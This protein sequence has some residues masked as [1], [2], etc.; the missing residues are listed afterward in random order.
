MEN[1]DIEIVEEEKEGISIGDIFKRIWHAKITLGV[2][3]AAVLVL[4]VVGIHDLYTKPTHVYSG[5]VTYQFRGASEGLYPN[6]TTFDY[7][8]LIEP[9]ALQ[10][11][12]DSNNSEYA[13]IDIQ[14]MIDK[15]AIKVEQ[16]I[17]NVYN[18][19]GEEVPTV[20]PN[21]I[22]LTCS[23]SYFDSEA[24]AK[25]FLQDVLEAPNTLANSLYDAIVYNQN[26]ELASTAL[27][28]EDQYEYLINQRDLIY[29]NYSELIS[30]F[31]ESAF[32][33]ADS[34]T[35]VS[36]ELTIIRQFFTQY[37]LTNLQS[38][39]RLN[40]YV[41]SNQPT[42]IDKL[43]NELDRL[44]HEYNLNQTKI[45]N[46][47]TQWEE[48]L[49]NASGVIISSPNDFFTT[50]INLTNT[51]TELYY[52]S[53]EPIANKLGAQLSGGNGVKLEVTYSKE[54]SSAGSEAPKTAP[55]TYIETLATITNQLT[56]YTDQLKT[57]TTYLYTTYAKPIYTLPSVFELSG[58]LNIILNGAIS[59][60]AAVILACLVAGIKG[61]IDMKREEKN[62]EDLAQE[63][64]TTN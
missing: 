40:G 34:T 64:G 11:V 17:T 44:V 57:T 38:E 10:A 43:K 46:L 12:K 30:T 37:N 26:L 48:M 56:S 8:S 15:N 55:K 33:G 16:A 41:K 18:D 7:R 47:Q 2:T 24:Q 36:Q 27:T 61:S 63:T 25:S 29:S 23:A 21:Y 39:A 49:T 51:N 59:F 19:A 20:L 28:Y 13:N 54:P 53:I 32:I 42:E 14:T 1:K 3:F 22:T 52:N 31:G 50:I 6:G 60:V 58:G 9:S 4:G 5:S 35:T 62:L 45:D